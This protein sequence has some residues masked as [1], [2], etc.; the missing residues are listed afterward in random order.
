M[1]AVA[2]HQLRY[3]FDVW[4]AHWLYPTAWMAKSALGLMNVPLVMTA[5]GADVNVDVET[6][7]GFRQY[8]EH[9]A[10]IRKLLSGPAWTTAVSPQ[11]MNVVTEIGGR[12][13]RCIPNGIAFS[14]IE[15]KVTDVNAVRKALNVPHG[16]ALLLTVAR[17][18]PSKGLHHI[19][20]VIHRLK[21][22]G[23]SFVWAIIGAGVDELG[24]R[25]AE[26]GFSDDVRL[27]PP[28]R[29]ESRDT[30]VAP[31][32]DLIDLYKSADLFVFPTHSESFGLVALEAMAAG[33]PVIASDVGGLQ[34]FIQNESNGILVPVGD[35]EALAEAIN[36]LLKNP[37]QS[38]RLSE[39]GKRTAAHYDWKK[40]ASSYTKLY[41]QAIESKSL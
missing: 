25:F 32:G 39:T 23:I 36:K 17:N 37:E 30:S 22:R 12:D 19:P 18:Q 26:A 3:K 16:A 5:H 6:A 31:H 27:M 29:K 2:A 33:T 21:S 10:R 34:S 28:L 35:T 13:V 20:E 15:S 24:P 4:H 1:L 38:H 7:Y 40:V 9:D 11:L 41:C 8:R 14:E